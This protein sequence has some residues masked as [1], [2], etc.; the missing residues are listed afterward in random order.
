MTCLPEKMPLQMISTINNSSLIQPGFSL[1][2]FDGRVFLFGQKGWPKRSCPTGIFL[3]DFKKE[4]LK[5]K[6]AYFSKDSCYLPPLRYPAICTPKGS[7][8]QSEK[9]PYF[10][11]GGKTPNN[12]LSDKLY[13]M[14]L[15]S[16]NSKKFTFRCT[17][18]ELAGEVPE[19]RYGHTINVVHSQGKSIIVI[20][21][22]RSYKALGER[23]TENWNSVVDCMPYIFLVD[24][25]FGCCTSHAFQELM[26]GFSFHLSLARNDTIYIIGGHSVESNTRPPN[27][28]RIK[29]DLPLGSPAVNCSVLSG[30]ISVSS[31][32]MTQTGDQE[33]VVVGGYHSD[34]QKRMVCNTINLEDNKIEIV[35]REAPEWTPDIKHCKI[36]FGSDMGNGA[37]LFGIPGDNRQLISDANYFY[38]LRCKEESD[39]DPEQMAQVCS[40]SSTEDAGESTP[41]E[42]S[43][44]FTFSFDID[45]YN[46]DDEE[47]E[48]ETGYW[49]TCSSGCD[50]DINTWVPLYSTELNKPAM[51]FCS[52][53]DGHWVHAQCMDLSEDMLIHLSQ[54][55]TKYFCPE[56]TSLA[57]G[58]QTPKETPPVEKPPMKALHRK[59]PMT[60]FTP[61][62]KSFI[63]KL[64]Q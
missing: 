62:K 36:W 27:L 64:F 5:L 34:N 37:I 14:S 45:T 63:R 19:A 47:D 16:K 6:P 49:I 51:I 9:C 21:G 30:G 20:V 28:Y 3:L 55:N 18:K 15:I 17:E 53:G 1:L 41:F 29:V 2:N 56:H 24:P 52:N 13:I 40:Q 26:G 54:V 4:E 61:A 23:T 10:I 38:L 48:S 32:I 25:E 12:E 44:E 8:A 58:L 39:Q 46:E 11:H 50:I 60:I 59:K 35:E 33:F 43:E 31:A 22:G 57:R 42:D 7:M